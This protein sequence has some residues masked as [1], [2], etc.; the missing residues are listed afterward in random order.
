MIELSSKTMTGPVIRLHPADNVVI[1]RVDIAAGTLVHDHNVEFREFDR[2]YAFGADYRPV[3]MLPPAL[4]ATFRGI[5]RSNGEVG[6]RNY[7]GVL[8]T[9][10]CSAT[11]VHKIA[12]WFTSE[13]L[14]DYPNVDGVVAFSHSIGCGMEMSGEPMALLRRTM[15]GYARHP[16]LA[17]ALIVG[18]GC[19][20][21]QLQELL[22]EEGLAP[23]ARLH[24]F[25]MQQSGG[26]RK[27]I[28]AGIEAV[29]ALLR[30][31]SGERTKSELLGL[32]DHEFVPWQIGIMS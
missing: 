9:V 18:L 11:V 29:K 13:R 1:A 14:A 2:D 22:D 27:T 15:A 21:N 26:T 5:V 31:T 24:T 28:E 32:G 8:S 19:E 6:T 20:R 10:N 17:A 4:R 3:E 16:N 23:N 7:I 12:E 30:V 25:T